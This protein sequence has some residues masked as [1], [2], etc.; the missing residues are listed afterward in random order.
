V[1]RIRQNTM[2]Y[3]SLFSHAIDQNM[4]Q[5]TINFRDDKLSTF[6]I[7]MNQRRYNVQQQM[8]AQQQNQL[9][10]SQI[11]PRAMLPAELERSFQVFIVQGQFAKKH[12]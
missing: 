4:P 2:R 12:I 8:A 5:P 1:D 11:D 7:L 10:G 3:V 6:E 9:G